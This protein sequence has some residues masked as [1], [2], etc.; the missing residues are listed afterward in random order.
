MI[1]EY[2]FSEE[3][4]DLHTDDIIDSIYTISDK[5]NIDYANIKNLLSPKILKILE[6]E[7]KNKKLL[8]SQIEKESFF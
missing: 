8:K 5:Y 3:V 7:C 4:L 6:N 2:E 1:N